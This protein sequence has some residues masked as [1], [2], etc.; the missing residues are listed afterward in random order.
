M[1]PLRTSLLVLGFALLAAACVTAP[2]SFS[3]PTPRPAEDAY[4]CALRKVNELGY[5]VT[6]TSRESGFISGTKQTSGLG[7][8]LLTGSQ[9]HDQLTVS[10]FSAG[11]TSRTIRVTAG[12]LDANTNALATRTTAVAPT[13]KG[14][15][16]AKA[17]LES[18]GTVVAAK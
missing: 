7:T 17:V 16:D 3:S 8:Q 2:V 1:P 5:T 10:V 6:N 9:Y 4:A 11:D 18:C 12:R 13:E 15:T 14:K